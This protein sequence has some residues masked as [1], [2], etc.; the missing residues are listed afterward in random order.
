MYLYCEEDFSRKPYV[1]C[2][3]HCKCQSSC[4]SYEKVYE[5]LKEIPISEFYLEKY[6]PPIYPLPDKIK[7]KQELLSKKEKEKLKADKEHEK[8]Q[9]KKQKELKRKQKALE[10]EQKKAERTKK[11]EAKKNSFKS[12]I[13]AKKKELGIAPD[14]K[15]RGRKPKVVAAIVNNIF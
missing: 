12:K 11:R 7:K 1:V 6:G 13:E 14:T 8:L 10:K 9:K 3:Y 2:I 15:K 5:E 4:A